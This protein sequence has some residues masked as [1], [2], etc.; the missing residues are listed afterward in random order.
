[1][2]EVEHLFVR[3]RVPIFLLFRNVFEDLHG[4]LQS[5]FEIG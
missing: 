2:D 3:P 5:G 1:M 4:L